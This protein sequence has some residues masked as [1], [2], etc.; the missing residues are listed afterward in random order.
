M[1]VGHMFCSLVA[2]HVWSSWL[3]EGY[4]TDSEDVEVQR[5]GVKLTN[6]GRGTGK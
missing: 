4:K 1:M 2:L 3:Q 6:E 5:S